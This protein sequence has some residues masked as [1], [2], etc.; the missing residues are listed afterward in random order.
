M[1]EVVKARTVRALARSSFSR[2]FNWWRSGEEVE[3][4]KSYRYD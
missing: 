4:P 3:K 1:V 2:S